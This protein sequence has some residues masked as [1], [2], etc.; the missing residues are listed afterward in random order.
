MNLKKIFINNSDELKRY[1]NQILQLFENCFPTPLDPELW[2]WAY[3]NNPNGAPLVSLYFDDDILVGHYAAIPVLLTDR[4][5]DIKALL[6]MTTMVHKKYRRFGFFIEQAELVYEKGHELGFE[7]VYGFPNK[8][9][10]PGFK[11]R[12]KWKLMPEYFV[13]SLEKQ[14]VLSLFENE[15]SVSHEYVSFDMQDEPQLRWRLSKPGTNCFIEKKYAVVKQFKNEYDVLHLESMGGELL[16][17]DVNYNILCKEDVFEEHKQFDYVFGYRL[18]SNSN[19]SFFL[20]PELIMSD[21]F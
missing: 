14:K 10:A 4:K 9:S 8:N 11:K 17:D 1:K 20:K 5:R 15:S 2:D 6:S 7:L 13:A 21:V 12:L 18:L 3:L 16:S 19:E